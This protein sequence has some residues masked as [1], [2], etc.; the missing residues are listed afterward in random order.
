MKLAALR[1]YLRDNSKNMTEE[2]INRVLDLIIK[3]EKA[4]QKS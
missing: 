2:E 1:Q 4:L 3:I